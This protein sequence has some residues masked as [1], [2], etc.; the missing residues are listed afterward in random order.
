LVRRRVDWQLQSFLIT[1][2]LSTPHFIKADK[3]FLAVSLID[4]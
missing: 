2:V 3:G 1:T 4:K